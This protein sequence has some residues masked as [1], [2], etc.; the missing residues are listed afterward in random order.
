MAETMI[1]RSLAALACAL[2][3]LVL[4]AA[5]TP[6]Y[7]NDDAALMA[8][9][10]RFNDDAITTFA[11]DTEPMYRLYNVTSGEHFYTG[12]KSERNYLSSIGWIYEGV[13][14]M[15]PK[16]G[17]QV[18]RLYNPYAGEHHYTLDASE[19][20]HLASVGWNYEGECW[21]S[22]VEGDAARQP[23][24]RQYNP[25]AWV[26][27]HNFTLD[28]S[29]RDSVIAAGWRDEGVG[30]YGYAVPSDFVDDLE[31]FRANVSGNYVLDCVLRLITLDRDL[32]GA[33][34]Y[35]ANLDYIAGNKFW[36]DPHYLPD[37]ITIPYAQAMYDNQGGNCYRFASLFCWMARALGYDAQ[38]VSGWVPSQAGGQAPHGWV[39]INQGG[40]TFVCDPDMAN[41]LPDYNWFMVTYAGAPVS[42]NSW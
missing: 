17:Y 39:E 31:V 5:A 10:A 12:D 9:T 22:P 3:A 42:Y 24:Y 40:S 21:K 37:S 6:A 16:T 8:G 29:E 33:F 15:A 35:V 20:D 38:V 14:W 30:W 27:T 19:R 32:R 25:Y 2:L 23:L 13:G 28:A 1:K 41:S 18:Y 11:D 34:N 26:G 7:A 36:G 4:G